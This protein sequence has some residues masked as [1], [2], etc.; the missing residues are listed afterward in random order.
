MSL[1]HAAREAAAVQF[2]ASRLGSV[3]LMLLTLGLGVAPAAAAWLGKL[4]LDELTRG[5]AADP[6]R[7][8]FYAVAG[9]GIVALAAAGSQLVDVLAHFLKLRTTALLHARLFDRVNRLVGV[10]QFEDPGY[11]DQL[12]MAQDGATEAPA[13][14]ASFVT[15]T[16]R[17]M[18]TA[19]AYVGVVFALWPPLVVLIVISAVGAVAAQSYLARLYI[20]SSA[21]IASSMR[22]RSMYQLVMLSAQAA[23]EIRLYGL[24]AFFHGRMMRALR[25]GNAAELSVTRRA[26]L[27]QSVFALVGGVI[28][29]AGTLV[30]AHRVLLGQSTIGDV[31]FLGAAVAGLQLGLSGVIDAFGRVRFSLGLFESFLTV[32]R[33]TE[34]LPAGRAGVPALRDGIELRDVWFRYPRGPWILRG[35]SFTIRRGETV[36]LVGLNGAGKSTLVKLLCRFY[37]PSRGSIRWDGADLRD[38]D[39]AE[40]RSRYGVTYQD[41]ME[42]D[43]TARESVGIGDL[44][45][46]GELSEV[47]RTAALAGIDDYLTGLPQ[48][49]DTML[50]RVF[51][52]EDEEEHGVNPSGGQWQRI[53]LARS[54]MRTEADLLILDEPSAGLDPLAE[55]EIH[56]TLRDHRHGRTCLLIS[57]RLST[58]RGADRIVVLDNGR[59]TEEGS[60]EELM[61]ADGR[62]A[63]LFRLQAS[64]Y[65][66][67]AAPR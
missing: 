12:R 2:R 25:R 36:G 15:D 21:T 49:Y 33:R 6:H 66:V 41:F 60:H 20:A 23:K 62:Y 27:N 7:V 22:R 63:A 55:H 30:V 67:E 10:H 14:V 19:A 59:I 65:D 35:A 16:V 58:L 37:D 47:R 53:A 42:F 4:L 57:H 40:L 38:L 43:L 44:P 39:S 32:E 29:A 17:G 24:G 3:A 31:A 52:D 56:A 5:H 51:F 8:T 13:A 48:G 61:A 50:S 18:I 64:G 9:A 46:A 28:A 11:Q 45:R 1:R 26:A 34:D 54:L